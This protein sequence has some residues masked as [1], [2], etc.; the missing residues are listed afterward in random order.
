M[1]K[2]LRIQVV[3]GSVRAGCVPLPVARWVVASASEQADLD[4]DLVDLADWALPMFALATPPAMGAYK[5]PLQKRWA[6]KVG[7]ADGYVLVSPEYNHGT[8]AVLKNSLDYLYAEWG[9]KPVAFV[10]FGNTGGARSRAALRD[11]CRAS[12]GT[13]RA[14]ASRRVA[15]VGA[16][17]AYV[18]GPPRVMAAGESRPTIVLSSVRKRATLPWWFRQARL[19]PLAPLALSRGQHLG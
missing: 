16:P 10:S 17:H 1:S 2:N 5:D 8:S 14:T 15:H 12:D 7:E 3:V 11:R 13:P 6:A 4:T 19:D 9:R 18:E